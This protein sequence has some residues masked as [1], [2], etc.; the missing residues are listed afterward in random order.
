M[1]RNCARLPGSSCRASNRSKREPA[2]QSK[3]GIVKVKV[4]LWSKPLTLLTLPYQLAKSMDQSHELKNTLLQIQK[5]IFLSLFAAFKCYLDAPDRAR[6]DSLAPP[7][8]SPLVRTRRCSVRPPT[9]VQNQ[10]DVE[11]RAL[12]ITRKQPHVPSKMR[13]TLKLP[14]PR[15]PDPPASSSDTLMLPSSSSSPALRQEEKVASF[16]MEFPSSPGTRKRSASE[17][18]G[19]DH[20]G[21]NDTAEAEDQLQRQ[22]S[23]RLM[24]ESM[25]SLETTAS[26]SSIR[27]K[28]A[29]ST[30]SRGALS[31]SG[32]HVGM[33]A[34][35]PSSSSSSGS[36]IA[37]PSKT[38]KR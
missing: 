31:K 35:R 11:K 21:P 14:S 22:R 15:A 38:S 18:C 12:R 27:R 19:S 30:Q 28:K 4:R 7:P 16:N 29:K 5:D 37:R 6:S 32:S 36:T 26:V 8:S 23:P 13:P 20:L 9:N 1:P 24:N 34:I 25:R 2:G 33:S 17:S 10:S 3:T